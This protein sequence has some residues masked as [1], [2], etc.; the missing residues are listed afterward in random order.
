MLV[1]IALTAPILTSVYHYFSPT[2]QP[3]LPLFRKS[4]HTAIQFPTRELSGGRV[5][6]LL[7]YHIIRSLARR[8]GLGPRLSI[9]GG[10]TQDGAVYKIKD[11]ISLSMPFQII[12]SDIENY[13]QC[14]SSSSS[15]PSITKQD[16]LSSGK[17]LQLLLS[18][19]TEPS[20]LLLLSKV[21]CPID[22]IGSVNVRNKFT[23]ID[24]PLCQRSLQ[25]TLDSESNGGPG[26]IARSKLDQRVKKVKRGWEFTIIVELR[27]D[28]TGTETG[29]GSAIYKQE[30]TMLQFHKHPQQP[31]I[32]P[33]NP[34]TSIDVESIGMIDIGKEEP[35]NWAR[36]SKDY[37]PIHTY[38][39]AARLLGF[40]SKIAHGNHIVSKAIQQ[41]S[42]QKIHMDK[43]MEG[44][45]KVEFKR[46][47]I[48]PSTLEIKMYPQGTEKK[49]PFVDICMNGK[50]AITINFGNEWQSS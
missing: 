4:N 40:K 47:I 36:L 19:L 7:V 12:S 38:S 24:L 6:L 41:L 14:L 23:L 1:L 35:W 30:F 26:L 10:D 39:T 9:I 22:P 29:T 43:G 21:N 3:L 34:T 37:N 18:A 5:T 11:D 16:I 48:V 20:M 27:L 17:H 42:D 13:L 46:P 33:P 25:N 31:S 44:W 2:F 15:S 8:I 49:E 28:Q 50:V 32:P 45:I